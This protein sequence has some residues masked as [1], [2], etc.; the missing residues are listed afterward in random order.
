M[1][2]D[3]SQKKLKILFLSAWYPNKYDPMLGL[4]VRNHAKAVSKLCDVSVIYTHADHTLKKN[5]YILESAT[6]ASFR[7]IIVYYKKVTCA[8]PLLS[9]LIKAHRFLKAFSKGYKFLIKN[10]GSPDLV[11]VNILTRTAIPALRLKRK[12]NIPYIITEHWSRY[13][14]S[15]NAYRGFVRK[16][17]TKL[18]VRKADAVTTVTDDLRDSMISHKLRNNNYSIVPN[19][20]DTELFTISP[21]KDKSTKTFVHI[22]CF[23]DKSKNI[24]GIIRAIARLSAE[25]TGFKINLVGEGMDF[26]EMKRLSDSFNLTDK[27]VFFKGLLENEALRDIVAQSDAT[28]LFSNYE[29][30]GIVL[31]ESMACGVPVVSTRTGL[32][33]NIFQNEMGFLV[34]TGNE[35]QL[36]DSMKVFL[37]G[38]FNTDKEKLR[39]FVIENYSSEIVGKMFYDIYKKVIVKK[40]PDFNH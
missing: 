7:E 38:K 36:I 1:Q 23:E 26:S 3:N 30:F 24:S 27:I 4:F 35:D 25:R 31:F 39:S 40:E 10:T 17:L 15:T 19:V 37:D 9:Q 34:D 6:E 20:V 33:K 22:S 32:I 2:P 5:E 16:W 14:P 18:I 8:I 29:T 12:Y 28:I 13:L 21:Q 11:H